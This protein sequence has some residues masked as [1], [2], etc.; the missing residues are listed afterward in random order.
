[1]M[2][3][4]ERLPFA[5]G[6]LW[7]VE[8]YLEAAGVIAAMKVGVHPSTVRRPLARTEVVLI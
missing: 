1:M 2:N 7:F 3:D 6:R 4:L 8:N 5:P